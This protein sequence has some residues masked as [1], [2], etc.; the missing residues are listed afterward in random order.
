MTVAPD[1]RAEKFETLVCLSYRIYPFKT[2]EFF[3]SCICGH[4]IRRQPTSEVPAAGLLPDRAAIRRSGKSTTASLVSVTYPIVKH[5]S[6][7]MSVSL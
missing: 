4:W 2:F 7:S 3:C 1:T 5:D 6:L